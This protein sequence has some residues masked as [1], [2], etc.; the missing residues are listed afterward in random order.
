MDIN[1][2][3]SVMTVAAFLV[4]VAILVWAYRPANKALFDDAAQLPFQSE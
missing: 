2:L 4:F 3:R 1:I